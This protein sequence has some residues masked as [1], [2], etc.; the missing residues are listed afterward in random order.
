MAIVR[1]KEENKK[2]STLCLKRKTKG[3]DE[4]TLKEKHDFYWQVQG[5]LNV[6]KRPWC[7]FVLRTDVDIFVQRIYRDEHLWAN[8]MYP[9]LSAFYQKALL[10]ELAVPH[11]NDG[12]IREPGKWVCTISFCIALTF[13]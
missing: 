12:G 4:L 11:L 8:V 13:T 9:K 7:D 10:P 5:Q 3:A 2:M 1:E 6:C